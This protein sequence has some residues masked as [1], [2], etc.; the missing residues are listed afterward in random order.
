MPVEPHRQIDDVQGKNKERDENERLQQAWAGGPFGEIAEFGGDSETKD[1]E[2]SCNA[3]EVGDEVQDVTGAIVGHGFFVTI[4]GEGVLLGLRGLLR[5]MLRFW[6]AGNRCLR[7]SGG[8][9]R[10]LQENKTANRRT[11]A[12]CRAARKEERTADDQQRNE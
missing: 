3:N 11:N 9:W 5:C 12:R 8:I 7:R 4:F 10:G 6:Q 2:N 1:Q